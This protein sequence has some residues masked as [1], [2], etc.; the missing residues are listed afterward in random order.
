MDKAGIGVRRLLPRLLLVLLILLGVLGF[1]GRSAIADDA[2]LTCG[3]DHI[4][5]VECSHVVSDLHFDSNA[6]H[7]FTSGATDEQGYANVTIPHDAIANI[8][9]LKVLINNVEKPAS[10]LTITGNATHHF[11]H[12]TF[13]FHSDVNIDI[14]FASALQIPPQLLLAVSLII[15]PYWA[16]RKKPRNRRRE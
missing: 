11:V 6:I 16:I 13:T 2:Y 7:F 8:D 15:G 5:H 1:S 3:P 4:C 12:F 9:A 10:E 14:V